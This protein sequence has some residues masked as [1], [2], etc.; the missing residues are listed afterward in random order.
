MNTLFEVLYLPPIVTGL[1]QP[2]EQG[3]TSTTIQ[4]YKKHLLR[5]L[6]LN[7]T[8][9]GAVKFLKQL[10]LRDCLLLMKSAWESLNSFSLQKAWKPILGDLFPSISDRSQNSPVRDVDDNEESLNDESLLDFPH[11]L[12]NKT[13]QLLSGP[14]CSDQSKQRLSKWFHNE[15][16]D[17]GWVPLSNDAVE[18]FFSNGICEPIVNISDKTAVIPGNNFEM[19]SLKAL[20]GLENF[21]DWLKTYK[22]CLPVH[23]FYIQ[24]LETLAK[25][26]LSCLEKKI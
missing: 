14:K 7:D 13:I 22:K 18:N 15:D 19:A 9:E 11:D 1:I 16:Y 6:L 8:Q 10:D 24:E 23:L 3:V 21:K 20:E 26:S 5:R 12:C 17:C 2:M 4:L 25:N